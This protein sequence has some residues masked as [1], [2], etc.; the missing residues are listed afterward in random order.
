[1][2]VTLEIIHKDLEELKKEVEN[3]KKMIVPEERITDDERAE[4][5]KTIKEMERGE[6]TRLEDVFNDS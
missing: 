4:I 5:R 3:L 6:E 1:M 2:A